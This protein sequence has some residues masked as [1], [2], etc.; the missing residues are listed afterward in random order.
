MEKAALLPC[1]KQVYASM[2]FSSICS[3]YLRIVTRKASEV[4]TQVC[5]A[6]R[7]HEQQVSGDESAK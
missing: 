3:S 7:D 6:T 5:M 1:Q 2:Q 4:M